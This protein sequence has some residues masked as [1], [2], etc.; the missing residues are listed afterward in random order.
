MK[1]FQCLLKEFEKLKLLNKI[2]LEFN[3][4]H[5]EIKNKILLLKDL[6]KL[7]MKKLKI[8]VIIKISFQYQII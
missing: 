7:K 5:L 4:N 1:E 6:M 8:Q 2:K 3:N